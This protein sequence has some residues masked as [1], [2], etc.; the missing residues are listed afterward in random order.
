MDLRRTVDRI[1]SIVSAETGQRLGIQAEDALAKLLRNVASG[2]LVRAAYRPSVPMDLWPLIEKDIG[3]ND[4]DKVKK[5][6][7]F[8][9]TVREIIVE[10]GLYQGRF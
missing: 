2:N 3:R 5:L 1:Q 10:H 8:T 9:G 6:G 4:R 7:P